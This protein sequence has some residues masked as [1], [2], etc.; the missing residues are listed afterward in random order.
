MGQRLCSDQQKLIPSDDLDEDGADAFDIPFHIITRDDRPDTGRCAGID[1]IAGLQLKQPREVFDRFRDV[2][3]KI[4]NVG[5]LLGFAI[6]LQPD[7][8]G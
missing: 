3:D 7:D 2:S 1:D 6:H 5:V 8:A 4:G